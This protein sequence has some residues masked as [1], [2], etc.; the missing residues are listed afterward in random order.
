MTMACIAQ[1]PTP[2]STPQQPPA[3]TPGT[4]G[5][6]TVPVVVIRPDTVVAIID[7]RKLTAGELDNITTSFQGLKQN[8]MS[9]PQMFL[10]RFGVLMALTKL[11][12]KNGLDQRPPFKERIEYARMQVLWQAQ[13]DKQYQD[14]IVT[15]EEKHKYYDENKDRFAF[16]KIKA[17]YLPFSVAPPPRK[18]PKEKEIL[19]ETEALTKAQAIVKE[20]RS[21]ADFVK[22]VKE[23]SQDA[24]SAGKDGDFGSLKKSDKIPDHIK[25]VIFAMKTGDISDPVKQPNGYYIFRAEEAGQQTFEQAAGTVDNEIRDRKLQEWLQSLG[26]STNVKIESDAYFKIKP[27]PSGAK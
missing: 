16:A 11:A 22:L 13:I 14:F 7:G 12:E 5:A 25:G 19:N 18:D 23:Y 21:G 9:N 4:I 20:A 8:M 24:T 26:K 10:E 1:T 15:P 6:P 2:S 17:I 27:S 3:P